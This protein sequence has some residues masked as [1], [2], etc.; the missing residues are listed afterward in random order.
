MNAGKSAHAR[1]ARIGLSP[2]TLLLLMKASIPSKTKTIGRLI[3]CLPRSFAPS[4]ESILDAA[5][6]VAYDFDDEDATEALLLHPARRTVPL[7]S[8]DSAADSV[9]L[10]LTAGPLVAREI[11]DVG[12]SDSDSEADS[13]ARMPSSPLPDVNF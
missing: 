8:S 6:W 2:T 10:P 11:M 4:E 3:K 9:V 13:S 12:L 7:P 5:E 1:H